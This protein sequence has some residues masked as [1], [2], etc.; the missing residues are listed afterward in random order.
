MYCVSSVI[1]ST[2]DLS[3][4]KP[5]CSRGSC[6]STTGLIRLH[7]N[8]S[9]I[10]NE[11]QSSEMGLYDLIVSRNAKNTT[12]EAN[13]ATQS[14][15][16]RPNYKDAFSSGRA[17]IPTVE[18]QCLPVLQLN[19]NCDGR[20]CCFLLCGSPIFASYAH[21]MSMIIPLVSGPSWVGYV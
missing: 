7:I 17:V 14:R 20:A 10:L 2:V 6:G 13:V 1:W 21:T 4:R 9:R 3:R 16:D 11:T 15:T 19:A 12:F 18:N 8:V 5:A